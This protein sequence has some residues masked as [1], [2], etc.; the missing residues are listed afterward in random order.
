MFTWSVCVIAVA[1]SVLA[2]IQTLRLGSSRIET[3]CL[4]FAAAH[5]D[6]VVC[7]ATGQ[8]WRDVL[9]EIRYL[10]ECR[11]RFR[12]G[13]WPKRDQRFTRPL[14]IQSCESRLESL[15]L[16]MTSEDEQTRISAVARAIENYKRRH[17]A[18]TEHA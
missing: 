12:M 3:V 13:K 14:T 6:A 15:A 10:S 18:L 11:R 17:P 1:A 4:M 8:D 9:S 2:V 7:S 5:V 16:R